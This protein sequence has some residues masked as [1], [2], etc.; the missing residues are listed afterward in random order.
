MSNKL[1]QQILNELKV[2]L[3][4]EGDAPAATPAPA[5][6]P[7]TEAPQLSKE[8]LQKVRAELCGANDAKC[9]K[10]EDFTADVDTLVDDLDGYVGDANINS[11][12]TI[13]TKYKDKNAIDD[14]DPNNIKVVSSMKRLSDLYSLDENGDSFVGDL[15]K[16]GTSMLS[17]IAAK[18]KTQIL[19]VIKPEIARDPEKEAKD[20]MLAQKQQAAQQQQQQAQ[21]TQQQQQ[22]AQ[23]AEQSKTGQM[24]NIKGNIVCNDATLVPLYQQWLKYVGGV[25][26]VVDG[27]YGPQTHKVAQQVLSKKGPGGKAGDPN[28]SKTTFEQAKAGNTVCNYVAG[29][30]EVMKTDIT[31]SPAWKAT[32]KTPDMLGKPEKQLAATAYQAPQQPAAAPATPA[33]VKEG[34]IKELTYLAKE[35]KRVGVDKKTYLNILRT[36]KEANDIIPSSAQAGEIIPA[37]RRDLVRGGGRRNKPQTFDSETLKVLQDPDM[38]RQLAAQRAAETRAAKEQAKL[39]AAYERGVADAT[40]KQLEKRVET[41]EAAVA[42]ERKTTREVAKSKGAKLTVTQ[43]QQ[44]AQTAANM[45]A[46]GAGG[47]ATSDATGGNVSGSGNASVQQS[48]RQTQKDGG[49]RDRRSNDDQDDRSPVDPNKVNPNPEEVPGP[50]PPPPEKKCPDGS[51][52]IGKKC[53]GFKKCPGVKGWVPEG[54]PCSGGGDGGGGRKPMSKKAK[55]AL[56]AA[57]VAAIGAGLFAKFKSSNAEIQDAVRKSVKNP[58]GLGDFIKSQLNSRYIADEESEAM[59]GIA[60]AYRDRCKRSGDSCWCKK[61]LECF[62]NYK[63]ELD[64][65]WSSVLDKQKADKLEIISIFEEFEELPAC[66]PKKEGA[67]CPDGTPAPGGDIEKCA[68]EKPVKPG[69][70]TCGKCRLKKGCKGPNVKEVQDKLVAM[71]AMDLMTNSQEISQQ[72]FGEG[73]E[74]AVRDFQASKKIKVDGIFGPQTAAKL[75]IKCPG[76]G[77][78]K[79]KVKCPDGTPAPGGD[80]EKCAK[81]GPEPKPEPT[82]TKCVGKDSSSINATMATRGITSTTQL[83]IAGKAV[84]YLMDKQNLCPEE[85]TL[86]VQA[87]IK[88]V[89]GTDDPPYDQDKV[90]RINSI[91]ANELNV[92]LATLQAIDTGMGNRNISESKKFNHENYYDSR[93]E[94]EAKVLFEKLIKRL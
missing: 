23:A 84:K 76:G 18:T 69:P 14:T 3:E 64:S 31:N 72:T 21:A 61:A 43:T 19:N 59:V 41:A 9:N 40:I 37:P 77:G 30:K 42:E 16:V 44:A 62:P 60:R 74:K 55:Y 79:D 83:P 65:K 54:Q 81:P 57:A 80:V 10:D 2:I 25:N 4:A 63:S 12:N 94:K 92:P 15:E 50:T 58:C 6:A 5:A 22:Q 89:V 86:R 66:K 71:K 82:P 33:Q 28:A 24:G 56:G 52:R 85:A 13:I 49:E 29:A 93:K 73:T 45:A 47:T 26:I 48:N 75:G 90:Q 11:I 70:D 88:K 53:P 68:S 78:K 46:G 1:R 35:G 32:K 38:K 51:P 87:L 27:V 20:K 34:I 91:L 7:A 17:G 8:E 36:L 39:Q 67:T